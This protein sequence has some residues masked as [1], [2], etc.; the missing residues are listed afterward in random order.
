[1]AVNNNHLFEVLNPTRSS[2]IILLTEEEKDS[3]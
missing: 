2:A 3:D 1:M